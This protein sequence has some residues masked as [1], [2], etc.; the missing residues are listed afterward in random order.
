MTLL[1]LAMRFV[2]E[3][4][5]RPGGADHPFIVWCHESTTMGASPDE[6][7]WCSSFVNRLAWMLRLPR[8]K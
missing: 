2:G 8:S 6:V 5:K 3:I 4:Q 7:P 1:D